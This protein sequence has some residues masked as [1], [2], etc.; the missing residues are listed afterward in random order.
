MREH[1]FTFDSPVRALRFVQRLCE[2]L[3]DIAVF[4]D[5]PLVVVWDGAEVGQGRAIVRLARTSG[6]FRLGNC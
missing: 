5:G 2:E 1:R 6:A 3:R 4:R